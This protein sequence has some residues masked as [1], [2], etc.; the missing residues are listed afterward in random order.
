METCHVITS[1]TPWSSVDARSQTTVA[2]SVSLRRCSVSVLLVVG[3]TRRAARAECQTMMVRTATPMPSPTR[4]DPCASGLAH[5]PQTYHLR[6]T[7]F[8]SEYSVAKS[9]SINA[10]SFDWKPN[11]LP[12]L[13]FSYEKKKLELKKKKLGMYLHKN[14][15]FSEIE[16]SVVNVCTHHFAGHFSTFY[17]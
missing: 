12:Q 2:C 6:I 16:I 15:L 5:I 14:I 3:S 13:I 7:P 4:C 9:F 8:A 17:F 1:S 11:K 10:H